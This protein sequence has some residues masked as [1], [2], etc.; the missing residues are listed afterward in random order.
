MGN[1]GIGTTSPQKKLHVVGDIG[2]SDANQIQFLRADNSVNSYISSTD[3][4]GITVGE[5]RGAYTTIM[6]LDNDK[7]L[8]STG[9]AGV[10]TVLIDTNGNVGIGTTAPNDTLS[11]GNAGA[12]PAGSSKT[13]HNFTSTYLATDDYALANYGLVKT[14][15]ANATSSLVAGNL[16][17]GALNG[18]I[19]NGTAGAGNV[20]I[21]TNNPLFK[22][23]IDTSASALFVPALALSNPYAT[24][25]SGQATGILFNTRASSGGIR[26]KGGI[27]FTNT[28]DY[29]RGSLAFLVNNTSN[30]TN[31]GL[32][33]AAMTILSSGN[34]GIGTTTPAQKLQVVGG[35]IG[36]DNNRYLTWKN[37]SS[38]VYDGEVFL[39]TSNQLELW[40][41][42]GDAFI[43]KSNNGGAEWM[44]INSGNVGIG[45]TTPTSKLYVNGEEKIANGNLSLDEGRAVVW[46]LGASDTGWSTGS[47]DTTS[48]KM[49]LK[50]HA[51]FNFITNQGNS[52]IN[53]MSILTGG[54]VGIGTTAPNDTLS[55]G[56]AG[57]APA[58]SSKTGHN[59][60][61][62]YLA[63]DDY[64][65]ANYG[66]VKTLVANATS[67]LASA[68]GLWSGTDNG[69]IWNG[70]AGAGNVGIGTNNPGAKLDVNGNIKTNNQLITSGAVTVYR[71]VVSAQLGGSPVTGAFVIHTNI[72]IPKAIMFEL[73]LRGFFYDGTAPFEINGSGYI[74]TNTVYGHGYTNTSNKKLSLRYALDSNNKVIFILGDV[75]DT[76]AYPK[77][78]VDEF[79]ASHGSATDAEMAGWTITQETDLSPY[80]VTAVVAD[81]TA[82][83]ASSVNAG[84]FQNGVYAFP[85][86]VNFA[87]N[88]TWSAVG[89]VGIGTNVPNDIFS[90]GN[91]GSAPIGSSKTGHNYT[92]TYLAT[93]DYALA[94]Y[95][96]VKT[97]VA[98]A[99]SSLVAW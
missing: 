34:V 41:G 93:D 13:G 82:V 27:A 91:S 21:G 74:Y 94:N 46:R 83:N 78:I 76:F 6:S 20:G 30:D 56:N 51:G 44:R 42:T 35:N 47:I 69:N 75:T 87:G 57:A 99:T 54:N 43:F 33:D 95:G 25:A 72:T 77:I 19:Y 2:I 90:I 48:Y 3:G 22:T 85:N 16:W 52:P 24:D 14:L 53:A 39:N 28:G 73:K 55:I 29:G 86:A 63:T 23:E 9:S 38:G 1:V 66:L 26:Y 92:S 7:F 15:V 79:W 62:T 60:T 37:N 31:A 96:L 70:D 18:N 10:N 49:T 80:T 71:N 50:G 40:S 64:A 5:N 81:K 89:N 84:T 61:S 32:S 67:S 45:T 11:I 65:L 68:I 97:L 98:N 4:S 12:A 58:G 59:F 17:N 36:L 8:F 88:G